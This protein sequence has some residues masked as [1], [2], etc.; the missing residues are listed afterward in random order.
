MS[1]AYL[2]VMTAALVVGAWLL[3]RA[4][5]TLP[6]S[7]LERWGIGLGALVGAMLGAKLPF[8]MAAWRLD[9]GSLVW[10]SDGKTIL[11]GLVG[12][13]LGVEVA[14]WVL[15]IRTK[16]GDAF[17]APV[18]VSVAIGRLGC[19]VGGCCSGLPTSLPWGVDFGAG[20]CHPTQ[21]YEAAFHAL[22]AAVL[23][24]LRQHGQFRYQLVKLYIA[25][26]CVFRFFTE[27]LRPELRGLGG[28]TGYQ[29]SALVIFVGMLFLI[30]RDARRAARG[31]WE[32]FPES[33]AS[34]RP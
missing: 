15:E 17:A 33:N 9:S 14:K 27:W 1:M 24:R 30:E 25:A 12:G 29:W 28:L 19:F 4:Q 7:R 31:G 26:Y 6:L 21:L 10:L 23:F 20:P 16:T 22:A 8:V 5:G 13:Y 11:T 3:R 18:A 2:L 32:F 34:N